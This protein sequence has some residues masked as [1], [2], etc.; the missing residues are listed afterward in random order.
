MAAQ[1]NRNGNE[2]GSMNDETSLIQPAQIE[3]AI[4]ICQSLGARR[5]LAYNLGNLGDIYL[6]TGDL[7]KARQLL[8]QALQEIS[9][10]QDVRGKAWLIADLGLVLLA[11]G[12]GNGASRRFTEAR[13]LALSQGLNAMACEITTGLAACAVLQGQ[14]DLAGKY[15]H[16]AWDY[17]ME[18]GWVGFNYIGLDFRT[19]AEVFDALGEAENVRAVLERG[20]QALMEVAD[21]INVPEWRQSFLEIVPN[22]RAL[23]D[24]WEQRKQ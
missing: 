11:T 12:D 21:T 8:D 6:D 7:R 14:L 17:V 1:R 16:E 15:V 23:M 5:P 22:N 2:N 13:E 19:C 24:M 4:Q 20:H 9:P 3:Q 10:T 18:H